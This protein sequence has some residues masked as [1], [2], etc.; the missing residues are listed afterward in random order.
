M[1]ILWL[2]LILSCASEVTRPKIY[3]NFDKKCEI[4]KLSFDGVVYQCYCKIEGT[5]TKQG[6]VIVFV[7]VAE[8]NCR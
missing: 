6:S 1:K 3:S 7:P 5:N 4:S 2:F 8:V